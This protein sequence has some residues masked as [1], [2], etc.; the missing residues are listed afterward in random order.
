[1]GRKL[2]IAYEFFIF[3]NP[4]DKQ[5]KVSDYWIM[6]SQGRIQIQVF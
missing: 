6:G 4:F 2:R 5:R 1:M 3:G